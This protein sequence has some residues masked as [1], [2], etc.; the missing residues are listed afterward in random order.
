MIDDI[1]SIVEIVEH[2]SRNRTSCPEFSD[3]VFD[4]ICP[5]MNPPVIQKNSDLMRSKKIMKDYFT[6][7]G[8]LWYPRNQ[9]WDL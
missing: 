1:P 9:A 8:K 4:L 7:L 6:L 5:S 2:F 3:F